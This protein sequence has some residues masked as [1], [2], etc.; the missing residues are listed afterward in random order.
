MNLWDALTDKAHTDKTLEKYQQ[1]G[2]I[3]DTWTLQKGFP[4]IYVDR[5][6]PSKSANFSQVIMPNC[7]NMILV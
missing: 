4:V 6:Y 5:N 3:M 7:K 1:V 2:D